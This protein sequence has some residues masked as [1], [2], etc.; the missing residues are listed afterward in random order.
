MKEKQNIFIFAIIGIDRIEIAISVPR[1]RNSS[2]LG[3]QSS[4][5]LY[6]KTEGSELFWK[7]FSSRFTTEMDCKKHL[8]E[9]LYDEPLPSTVA[10]VAASRA[11]ALTFKV[12]LRFPSFRMVP[13]NS[14]M[15][16]CH[17]GRIKKKYVHFHPRSRNWINP[18]RG[19][20]RQVIYD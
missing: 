13:A 17:N 2:P 20:E 10:F 11:A 6:I 9:A 19:T 12:F 16:G 15:E 3:M 1:Y 7:C 8:S 4:V 14:S 18:A 5:S